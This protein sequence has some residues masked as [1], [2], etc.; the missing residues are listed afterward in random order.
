MAANKRKTPGSS[1][2]KG[3]ASTIMEDLGHSTEEYVKNLKAGI[4]TLEVAGGWK[5]LQTALVNVFKDTVTPF[6]EKQANLLSDLCKK[7]N[8]LE[9]E[10][11]E[12]VAKEMKVRERIGEFEQA[13]DAIQVKA[14]RQEMAAKME[15]AVTMVKILDLDFEREIDDHKE[16]VKE[17]KEK[18][19]EK[20]RSDY[21]G[22]YDELIKKAVTQVLAKKTTK[23]TNREGVNIWTAPVVLTIQERAARWEMEDVLRKSKIYPTFHW[24]KEFLEPLKLLKDEIKRGGVSEATHYIRVRPAQVDN[25]WRIRADMRPKEGNARFV[26]CA[27][28]EMPPLDEDNRLR[29]GSWFRPISASWAQVARGARPSVS[30]APPPAGGASEG[31]MDL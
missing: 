31:D 13:R 27:T 6:A 10:K 19:K 12:L 3:T 15:T 2:Y 29:A 22:K 26:H 18:L 5:Q 28:W 7:V 30:A 17:A 16:L 24:P 21:A 4:A 8:D 1:P 14:S 20:V 23:R 11:D 25:K 9:E